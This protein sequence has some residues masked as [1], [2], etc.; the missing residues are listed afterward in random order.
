MPI[1]KASV[2]KYNAGKLEDEEEETDLKRNQRKP[3]IR[4][5]ITTLMCL[6]LLIYLAAV[7]QRNYTK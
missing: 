5:S 3:T 6:L 4:V 7:F 1:S 2:L